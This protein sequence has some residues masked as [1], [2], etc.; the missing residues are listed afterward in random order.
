VY[1]ALVYAIDKYRSG[2]DTV[3]DAAFDEKAVRRYILMQYLMPEEE[4]LGT[5]E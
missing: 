5:E 1:L 4:S 3:G 2:H